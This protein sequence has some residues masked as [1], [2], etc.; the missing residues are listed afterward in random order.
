MLDCTIHKKTSWLNSKLYNLVDLTLCHQWQGIKGENSGSTMPNF[1]MSLF[2]HFSNSLCLLVSQHSSWYCLLGT[3][4]SHSSFLWLFSSNFIYWCLGRSD[5]TCVHIYSLKLLSTQ[6]YKLPHLYG[7]VQ[8]NG[9]NKW[10]KNL[11][12]WHIE[13]WQS[14]SQIFQRRFCLR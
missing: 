4:L 1:F 2:S 14:L 13:V 6:L 3:M 10:L 8:V 7:E 5:N 9:C 11:V 12:I